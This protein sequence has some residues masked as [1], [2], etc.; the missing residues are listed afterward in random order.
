[1]VALNSLT[2]ACLKFMNAFEFFFRHGWAV[3]KLFDAI[4]TPAGADAL[5]FRQKFC[6]IALI[7]SVNRL[8]CPHF[9]FCVQT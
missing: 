7:L 5:E 9:S 1:M 4:K 3:K 8:S 2:A 6:E